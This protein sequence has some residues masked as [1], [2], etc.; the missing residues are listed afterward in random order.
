MPHD[1][2]I[3]PSDAALMNFSDPA[4]FSFFVASAAPPL[5]I[6]P[7]RRRALAFSPVWPEPSPTAGIFFASH[8]LHC[9]HFPNFDKFAIGRRGPLALMVGGAMVKTTTISAAAANF[10]APEE[11]CS[12]W[13]N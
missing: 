4:G 3:G 6:A 9:E 7:A 1:S 13:G 2:T 12:A 5:A 8:R 10:F 11:N